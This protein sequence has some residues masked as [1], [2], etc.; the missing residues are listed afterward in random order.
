LNKSK[1]SG[2]VNDGTAV[3][4]LVVVVL[5]PLSLSSTRVKCSTMQVVAAVAEAAAVAAVDNEDSVQWRQ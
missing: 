3:G 1:L 4:T 5:V 2:L